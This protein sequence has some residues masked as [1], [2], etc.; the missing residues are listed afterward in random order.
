MSVENK[1][2]ESPSF[3][4]L[5]IGKEGIHLSSYFDRAEAEK[6]AAEKT[7]KNEIPAFVFPATMFV[8]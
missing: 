3:V 8:K 5:Q 7:N 2:Q 4:V 1:V 6:V